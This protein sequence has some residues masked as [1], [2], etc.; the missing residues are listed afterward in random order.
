MVER[1]VHAVIAEHQPVALL[2]QLHEPCGRHVRS[3]L[4]WQRTFALANRLGGTLIGQ[5]AALAAQA[6]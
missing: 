3:T 2:I 4:G 1:D 6:G 5:V